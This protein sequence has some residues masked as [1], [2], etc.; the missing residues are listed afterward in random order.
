MLFDSGSIDI[1]NLSVHQ[2][3]YYSKGYN[4]RD[5]DSLSNASIRPLLF[6]FVFT[7]YNNTKCH[8]Y[9]VFKFPNR[10]IVC[11]YYFVLEIY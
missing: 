11:I 10:Y 7:I 6:L 9:N 4:C 8:I 5:I 3:T 2:V 1:R